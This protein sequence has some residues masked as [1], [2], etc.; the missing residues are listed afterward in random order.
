MQKAIEEMDD[1]VIR[2]AEWTVLDALKPCDVDY[3]KAFV[4]GTLKSALKGLLVSILDD[5]SG[6]K[7]SFEVAIPQVET[8]PKS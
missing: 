2:L 7:E 8:A 5:S 3:N 4:K 6:I 1:C